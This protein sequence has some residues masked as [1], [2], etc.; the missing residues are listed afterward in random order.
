MCFYKNKQTIKTGIIWTKIEVVLRFV[1]E[2]KILSEWLF[3]CYKNNF[4]GSVFAGGM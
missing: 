2:F 4:V 1:W 3:A